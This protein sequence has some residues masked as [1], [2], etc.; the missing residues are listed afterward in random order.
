MSERHEVISIRPLEGI[1]WAI[2]ARTYVTPSWWGRV[3]RGQQRSFAYV[4][5]PDDERGECTRLAFQR[6]PGAL[7]IRVPEDRWPL[8]DWA[9]DL[10]RWGREVT[11]RA[12]LAAAGAHCASDWR[13]RTRTH[14]RATSP[15]AAS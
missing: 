8:A 7:Q 1:E 11:V 15:C 2:T 5:I 3:M 10:S 4:S 14:S 12:A 6:F 9:R 13:R